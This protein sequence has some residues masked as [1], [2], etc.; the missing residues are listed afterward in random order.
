VP[1]PAGVGL[2][3]GLAAFF[4]LLIGLY[5]QP[6]IKFAQLAMLPLGATP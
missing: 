3:V 2:A 4:V 6:F 5:P 1:V